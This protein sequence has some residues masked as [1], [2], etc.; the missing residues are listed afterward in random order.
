[1]SLYDILVCFGDYHP[2]CYFVT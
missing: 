2:L 1:M